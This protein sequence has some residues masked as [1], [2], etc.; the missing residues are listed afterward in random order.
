LGFLDFMLVSPLPASLPYQR[1]S[2]AL[3]MGDVVIF[4]DEADAVGV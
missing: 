3:V 4:V 1:D 2:L